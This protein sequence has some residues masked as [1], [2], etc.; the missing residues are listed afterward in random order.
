MHIDFSRLPEYEGSQVPIQTVMISDMVS[1]KNS[2]IISELMSEYI[3][4][5]PLRAS[6]QGIHTSVQ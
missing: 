2:E 4:E 3:S 5:V 6:F 1:E